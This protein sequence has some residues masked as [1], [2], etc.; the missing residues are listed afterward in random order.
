MVLDESQSEKKKNKGLTRG[1]SSDS[2]EVLY[3]W[4]LDVFQSL[5][6]VSPLIQEAS[7]ELKQRP[8]AC[9]TT[10]DPQFTH[11]CPWPKR[12]VQHK[13]SCVGF[14]LQFFQS[15]CRNKQ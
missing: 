2:S 4:Q 3:C 7:S 14:S 13:T 8:V 11:E 1:Y 10:R 15:L 9:D 12:I 5:G 6:D